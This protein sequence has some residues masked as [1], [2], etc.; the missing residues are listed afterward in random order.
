MSKTPA[1][2]IAAAVASA[3]EAL[4]AGFRNMAEQKR[5]AES[6]SRAYEEQ[7]K[8]LMHMVLAIEESKRTAEQ[9][10]V[11]W[12]LPQNTHQWKPKHATQVL[13]A[14]AHAAE[15]VKSIETIAALYAQIKAAPITPKAESKAQAVERE[16]KR[17]EVEGVTSVVGLAVAP[18]KD[19]AVVIARSRAEA[20]LIQLG[21]ALAGTDLR[22]SAP[23]PRANMG[24]AAHLMAKQRY[25]LA[26]RLMN[27]TSGIRVDDPQPATGINPEVLASMVDQAGQDAAA[28]FDAYVI[29]LEGKVGACD[30]AKVDGRSLWHGS[31]LTVTKGE[32]VER[33]KTQQIINVSVLGTVFNQWPTRLMK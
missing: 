19:E 26:R 20:A 29:K 11:Y 18:L 7:R 10:A 24:R 15:A 14:M 17:R 8:E 2:R 30:T 3:T 9:D 21:E 23:Y 5:A 28:S 13:A 1:E 27:Y 33:W 25:Q 6:A 12:D 31:I 22:V 16:N 4:N 32:A